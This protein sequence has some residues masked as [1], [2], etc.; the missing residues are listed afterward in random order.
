M[1]AQPWR[2]CRGL[3]ACLALFLAAAVVAADDKPTSKTSDK[4]PPDPPGTTLTMNQFRLLFD[5]WDLNGDGYLD[6]SE[7]AKAFRGPTARPFDYKPPGKDTKKDD[8]K[9]DDSGKDSTTKKPSYSKYPDYNFLIQLDQ[10]NDEQISRREFMDW[11]R[12]TSV[13]LK[14]Q[15]ELQKKLADLQLKLAK[16]TAGTKQYNRLQ[17]QLNKEQAALNKLNSQMKAFDSKLMQQ[18]QLVG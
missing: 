4:E 2:L 1:R 3:S 5:S 15:A 12:D 13:Q 17:A 7:L 14:Q 18:L 9:P 16:A 11:A 8:P 6:K 10:D